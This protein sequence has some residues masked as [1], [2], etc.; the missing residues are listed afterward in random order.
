MKNEI[1]EQ[2]RRLDGGKAIEQA[3]ADKLR[4]DSICAWIADAE[5]GKRL[6]TGET[7]NLSR[8]LLYLRAQSIDTEYARGQF[9][10]VLPINANVPAG[11]T[12]YSVPKY[13]M[14]GVAKLIVNPADDLPSVNVYVSETTVGIQSYG[15]SYS[16][17]VQDLL[18][19]AM[20]GNMLDTKRQ[21]AV[22][23]VMDRKHDAIAC[24]GDSAAGLGGFASSTDV[25]VVTLAAVGTWAAKSAAH[26]GYKIF[27]DIQALQNNIVGDTQGMHRGDTLAM[28]AATADYV[29]TSV[30]STTDNR[31]VLKALGDAGLPTTI[32]EWQR[33]A[34]ADAQADGPRVILFEKKNDVVEYVAPGGG[35]QEQP[36]EARNLAFVVNVWGRSAGACIYRPKAVSY[37]DVG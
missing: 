2:I 8:A 27:D 11:A 6:D 36:A 3:R 13:D 37:M 14:A 32:V 33:L 10:N 7:A 34:L 31:T 5:G 12:S 30:M 24:T 19:A 29:R 25:D 28:D 17:S 4:I 18:S 16:Y 26:T 23:D 22:R 9:R 20:S 15:A 1:Y 21:Q 35:Y